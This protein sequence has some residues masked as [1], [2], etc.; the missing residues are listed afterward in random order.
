[1][2][3]IFFYK[4]GFLLKLM[5]SLSKREGS[6]KSKGDAQLRRTVEQSDTLQGIGY[7]NRV[8]YLRGKSKCRL[9]CMALAI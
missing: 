4:I 1:M 7:A 5:L 6:I 2:P 3:G 8:E 9:S